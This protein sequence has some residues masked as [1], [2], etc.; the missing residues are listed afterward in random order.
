MQELAASCVQGFG[1]PQEE[2][3][4]T[5][6]RRNPAVRFCINV[7]GVKMSRDFFQPGGGGHPPGRDD[8]PQ[9]K[10]WGKVSDLFYDHGD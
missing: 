2:E 5:V 1:K 7:D 10:K 4:E 3:S 6:S 9:L 8:L